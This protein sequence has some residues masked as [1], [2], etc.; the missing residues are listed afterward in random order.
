MSKFDIEGFL[1]TLKDKHALY[2]KEETQRETVDSVE[3]E[4][5]SEDLSN[6]ILQVLNPN[7]DI[8]R[9]YSHQIDAINASTEGNNVV[10]ESP[11]ASGKTLSFV[12]PMIKSG[13]LS[14]K[15]ALLVYPMKSVARDQKR[16]IDNFCKHLGINSA[17]YDGDTSQEEKQKIK[18]DPPHILLTNPHYMHLSFLQ[19]SEPKKLWDKNNF[20]EK[21]SFIGFDEAHIYRGYFGCNMALLIRR[22]LAKLDRIGANPKIFMSTA[23]C[24][25]PREHAEALTG[26]K[27]KLI[28][29]KRHMSPERNFI[30]VNHAIDDEQFLNKFSSR[31]VNAAMSCLA[32]GFP[33]LIFCPSVKFAEN[34]C[35]KAQEKA[36][37]ENVNDSQIAIYHA[38]LPS[39]EKDRILEELQKSQ[40]TSLKVVFCTNALEIG[41]DI[42]ELK[43]IILAGF[44]DNIAAAKQRIGRAGRASDADA[45][46]LYYPMNNPLDKF[47]AANLEF[48]LE[49]PLDPIALDAQ[50]EEAIKKHVEFLLHEIEYDLDGLDENFLGEK[51]FNLAKI[52]SERGMPIQS[53]DYRQLNMLGGIGKNYDMIV[54]G[55]SI[56]NIS[57][58]R[59]FKEAY[60]GAI[61]VHNGCTYRVEAHRENSI[62]LKNEDKNVRTDPVFQTSVDIGNNQIFSGIKYEKDARNVE[63]HFRSLNIGERLNS[64]RLV[65]NN[66]DTVLSS[67]N[68]SIGQYHNNRYAFV[69]S[70]SNMVEFDNIALRTLEQIVRI[71]AI[72][73]VPADR[74]DTST[75]SN[76]NEKSLY[77]YENYEG[78]IGVAR[79]VFE[80]WQD[81]ITKGIKIAET[82]KCDKGCPNCILPPRKS[83]DMDKNSGIKLA[84]AIL[85]FIESGVEK[86]KIQDN[87]WVKI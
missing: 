71:G 55:E 43:G 42:G 62:E 30:F 41:V 56:G 29:P 36:K 1:K 21:L 67:S 75:H 87:R 48:F 47:F 12:V 49:S 2:E 50:N 7:G 66:T 20:L 82:C 19:Y 10:L 39:A 51:F 86:Y 44:P 45:F 23:T 28:S 54:D 22:F 34:A 32:H 8:K 53:P 40:K 79:R 14:G 5:A 37:K 58:S 81:V 64:Y 61:L 4:Y 57:D 72:F 18:A 27:F 85:D 11:T 80:D 70:I 68:D 84:C 31:I 73:V 9:L 76:V 77:L 83:E 17:V 3:P 26:K 38:G 59:K 74:H 15:K 65:D 69:M 78:G 52:M 46:V 60:L 25:N 6:D 33:T 13:L 35:K 63:I 16:Q 24:K